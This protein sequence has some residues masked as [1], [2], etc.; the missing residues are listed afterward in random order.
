MNVNIG[1]GFSAEINTTNQTISLDL[2][3]T[4]IITEPI[5]SASSIGNFFVS[6]GKYIANFFTWIISH[7]DCNC[8]GCC[9]STCC[10]CC[11]GTKV[12]P[13]TPSSSSR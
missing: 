7:C 3:N 1:D 12:P 6:I 9:Y 2:N 4:P 5:P 13:A 11:R 8:T 10:G